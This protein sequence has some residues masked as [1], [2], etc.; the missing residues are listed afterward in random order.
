MTYT[1]YT[2]TVDHIIAREGYKYLLRE[3]HDW[4]VDDTEEMKAYTAGIVEYSARVTGKP[5]PKWHRQYA[6]IY[7]ESMKIPEHAAIMSEFD[8]TYVERNLPKAIPE[9]LKHNVMVMEVGNAV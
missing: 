3:E 8:P 2:S 5:L 4:I 6:D 1:Q 7:L 9:F